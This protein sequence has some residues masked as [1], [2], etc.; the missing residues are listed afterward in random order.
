MYAR[1]D[2]TKVHLRVGVR[3]GVR[4]VK[5]LPNAL[6]N[7]YRLDVRY[8]VEIYLRHILFPLKKNARERE[9]ETNQP[10]DV[11]SVAEHSAEMNHKST[12]AD[13]PFY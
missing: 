6:A 4:D 10:R 2:E 9:R 13:R 3:A 1:R 11:R 5:C 8:N 12:R 7:E